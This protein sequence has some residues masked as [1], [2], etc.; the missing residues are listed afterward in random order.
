MLGKRGHQGLGARGAA[1]EE[2]G[3]KTHDAEAWG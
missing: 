2:G 1:L 3:Q